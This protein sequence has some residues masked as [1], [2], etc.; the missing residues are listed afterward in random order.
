MYQFTDTQGRT[1]QIALTIGSALQVKA[2]LQIDL[3]QPE[4][5]DPPLF[6]R[7]GTDEYL[8]A[9]VICELLRKQMEGYSLT[10]ADVQAGFDGATLLAAAEA[11]WDELAGFSQSRGRTDRSTAVRKQN[12]VLRAAIKAAE[13]KV[14]AYPL[15]IPGE[16][17]GTSPG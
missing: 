11:F 17:S 13:A 3:L 12:A 8:L 6:S 7:L 1:W 4:K 15:T 9:S 14:E 16:A 5:G 10:E 2:A